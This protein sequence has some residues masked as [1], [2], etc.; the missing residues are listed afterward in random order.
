M[1]R[2]HSRF[3]LLILTGLL[4]LGATNSLASGQDPF[5]SP[6]GDSDSKEGSTTGTGSSRTTKDK[7]AKTSPKEPERIFKT[8]EEWQKILTVDQF[9]VTRRKA[10]EPAF[11]GKYS[12]GHFKGTFLCVCCG[13]KL[14]DARHKFESGTGWP[15]FWRPV[16]ER[17]IE[18]TWDYS[19]PEA[20]VEV[21]CRRCGAH[22]G[23]VFQDG[24]PP[25]GLRFCINSL[26]LKLDSEKARQAPSSTRKTSRT[27][28]RSKSGSA[29]Q[30]G[31][32]DATSS[33]A[34]KPARA[35]DP[36]S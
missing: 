8:D 20:R 36:K 3:P 26:S 10:T 35:R 11:S 7:D 13:A 24:P 18:T 15:S 33:A 21:T 6:P 12:H 34:Q 2:A 28:P 27:A 30:K 31:D 17:V 23:H 9:L 16:T 22:L 1:Q 25:T 19:E 29:P 14:F 4:W 32:D 5:Q